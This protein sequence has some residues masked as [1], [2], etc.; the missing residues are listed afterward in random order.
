MNSVLWKSMYQGVGK[1]C[2]KPNYVKNLWSHKNLLGK[3]LFFSIRYYS[4]LKSI[5]T[6]GLW[7]KMKSGARVRAREDSHVFNEEKVT[8]EVKKKWFGVSVQ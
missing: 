5:C 8:E 4:L 3:K 2:L 1:A 6:I 7:R